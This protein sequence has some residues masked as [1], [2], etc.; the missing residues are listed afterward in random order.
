MKSIRAGHCWVH[1]LLEHVQ[2][3]RT[4]LPK[5]HEREEHCSNWLSLSLSLLEWPGMTRNDHPN[6]LELSIHPHSEVDSA[7]WD[8]GISKTPL[9]LPSLFVAWLFWT[10]H[11]KSHNMKALVILS[12]S[13]SPFLLLTC[14]Y[15]KNYFCG[16]P[17]D[18]LEYFLWEKTPHRLPMQII[19]PWPSVGRFIHALITVRQK[20]MWT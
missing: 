11:N 4:D 9:K 15:E 18:L 16:S 20:Q 19:W 3:F 10:F 17:C 14:L 5:L 2:N 8:W 13:W 12:H 7:Q 6:K 1:K